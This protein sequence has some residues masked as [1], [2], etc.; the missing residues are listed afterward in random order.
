[1]TEDSWGII[2]AARTT[3]LFD[4]G[5]PEYDA[6][7]VIGGDGNAHLVLVC[8]SNIGDETA[9]YDSRC[10]D[11]KHEQLGPLPLNVVKRITIAQRRI[12][13]R[14]GRRTK[15]GHRCQ[16]PVQNA[17]D[18]CSCHRTPTD[19]GQHHQKGNRP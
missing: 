2:D 4:V 3:A 13:H 1:M 18:T 16:V 5:A 17:G 6:A 14:C 9:L 19:Q 12:T 11:V 8:R 10:L 15:S 7:T